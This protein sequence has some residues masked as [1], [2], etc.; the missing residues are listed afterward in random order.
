MWY[1]AIEILPLSLSLEL[2]GLTPNRGV[3]LANAVVTN[4]DDLTTPFT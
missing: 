1:L 3:P 2:I 4:P